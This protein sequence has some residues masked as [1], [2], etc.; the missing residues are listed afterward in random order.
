MSASR[1]AKKMGLKSLKIAMEMTGQSRQNL[2]NW[3][4]DKPDLFRV[5]I[6]GCISIQ[7]KEL[8]AANKQ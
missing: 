3:Y 6:E 7:K 2:Q 8:E 1:E 4:Q 5:I